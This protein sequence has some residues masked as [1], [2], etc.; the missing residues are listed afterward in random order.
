M[1]TKKQMLESFRLERLIKKATEEALLEQGFFSRAAGAIKGAFTGRPAAAAAAAAAPA[2]AAAASKRLMN[3][4][5]QAL[6]SYQTIQKKDI[7][8]AKKNFSP[9]KVKYKS[10]L[11]SGLYAARK[12]YMN[13]LDS[14]DETFKQQMESNPKVLEIVTALQ[15]ADDELGKFMQ[16]G[17]EDV[18]KVD[19]IDVSLKKLIPAIDNLIKFMPQV[20]REQKE[21]QIFKQI[22]Q[23]EIK[24]SY[25]KR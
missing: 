17:E 9:E 4:L 1:T 12:L 15:S 10:P 20:I 11:I 14:A 21:K 6:K 13:A 8:E 22:I 24:S 2:A 16:Y 3:G 18:K 25:R 7:P 5:Q 23:K 19:N